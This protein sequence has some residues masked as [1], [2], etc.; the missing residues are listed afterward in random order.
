MLL[1][2][3]AGVFIF[4]LW[5]FASFAQN[6]IFSAEAASDKVGL[7]DQFQV[8][9]TLKNISGVD[10]FERPSFTGFR[11][12]GGPVQSIQIINGRSSITLSY[13]L[14]ALK[15]GTLQITPA[16]A[17]VNG[18]VYKSNPIQIT[19]VDGSVAAQSQRAQRSNPNQRYAP[20]E[21]DDPLAEADQMMRQMMED[22]DRLMREMERRRQ[23]LMKQ[24]QQQYGSSPSQ[25][26]SSGDISKNLYIKAEADN[27][28]PYVGQQINVNYKVYFRIPIDAGYITKLPSLNGFWSEDFQISQSPQPKIEYVNGVPFQTLLIKKTAVFPQKIGDLELD[29]ATAECETPYGKMSIASSPVDIHVKPLPTTNQPAGFTGAVGNFNAVASLDKT[30]LTTDDVGT[31]TFT[32]S[33][34]GNI[35]L[36]D[37][38]VIDFPNGLGIYD[39]QISDTI[40]SRSPNLIGKKTF[41]YNFNPQNPGDYTIPAISFSYF[42]AAGNSYKTI[43]TQPYKITVTEGKHYRDNL[44]KNKSLPG[45][46]HNIITTP[47]V[48]KTPS[49]PLLKKAWYW[50]MY[51]FPVLAF[52]GLIAYRRRQD[53]MA[54]NAAYYK[55]QKANKVAWKRLATAR[56]LLPNNEHK[57]FY[58]EISKAVWLYL[59]DKLSIPISNLSKENI[60]YSLQAKGVRGTLISRTEQLISECEMALYSPSGSKQQRVDML[61]DAGDVIG[62]YESVLK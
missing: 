5:S 48:S 4:I 58:E 6:I 28:H 2:R 12:L 11:I 20:G 34:G 39:P 55:T 18:R 15:K 41:T 42:D 1:K 54:N 27:T 35:K 23:E 29:P 43:T 49:Q 8:D 56:R 7:L 44:A 16:Q 45:D 31:F 59:S 53:D 60:A 36:I 9:F 33:G 22:Q 52:L 14:Q 32:V 3:F 21:D 13:Y 62:E 47:L 38:P 26:L 50:S 24:Y 40:T 46:I 30:N 51:G 61:K 25:S 57:D 37:N 10:D 17:V 19:V